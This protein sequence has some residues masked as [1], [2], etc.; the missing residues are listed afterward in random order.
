MKKK[1]L[2]TWPAN[3]DLCKEDL[4]RFKEFYDARIIGSTTWAIMCPKCFNNLGVGLGTGLGQQYD[5]KTLEKIN[6]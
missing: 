4:R 6:G 5:S 1:W 3:C 2:G